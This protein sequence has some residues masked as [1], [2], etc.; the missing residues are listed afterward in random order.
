MPNPTV[1]II[2]P[3]WKGASLVG[4]TIESVI[5]QDYTDWEMI[6][7][8]DCSPDE[9]AGA[10]VVQSYANKDARIKLIRANVNR[11]SSGARNQAMEAATGRYFAFLDSD[12]IWHPTYLSTMM[13]H[14][15]ENKDKSVAIFFTGYRRI[16][17]KCDAELLAPYIFEGKRTYKQLLHH[18]PIFPSAAIVDTSKL[19]NKIMFNEALKALRDDY[20]YWL[21]IM[22]NGLTAYGYGDVLVDYRMRDDSMT[23]SKT[24][25]IKP[26]WNIYR[27]VLNMNVFSS[28]YYLFCWGMNGLKK[29]KMGKK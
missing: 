23:A 4:A 15:E 5:K 25:M 17:S 29:Y 20:A 3:M 8:D 2:T 1:S 18:C 16:N 14:I 27:K 21:E 19:S 28:A 12:D 11:G 7:V 26:Q 6:I 10:A 13:K 9:G 24:K 22:K